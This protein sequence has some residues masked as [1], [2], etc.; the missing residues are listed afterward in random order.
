MVNMR[1]VRGFYRILMIVVLVCFVL[2]GSTG[3]SHALQCTHIYHPLGPVPPG[4]FPIDNGIFFWL[5][6][7]GEIVDQGFPNGNVLFLHNPNSLIFVPEHS[8]YIELVVGNMGG[9]DVMIEWLDISWG[10]A[11]VEWVPPGDL[12]YIAI[13]GPKPPFVPMFAVRLTHEAAE[14]FVYEVCFNPV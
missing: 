14:A 6:N 8:S 11:N 9:S 2:P 7:G 12:Y 13:H 4:W 10:I 1:K 5:P 3:V